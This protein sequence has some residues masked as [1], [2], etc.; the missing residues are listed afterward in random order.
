ML[1]KTFYLK[2]N[3]SAEYQKRGG[4]WYK[5]KVGSKEAF[6]KVD[7]NGQKVLNSSYP[8]KNPLYFYSNVVLIGGALVVGVLGYFAYKKFAKKPLM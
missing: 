4:I 2:Y 6:Y 7:A 8:S 3:P 1:Y 5:R